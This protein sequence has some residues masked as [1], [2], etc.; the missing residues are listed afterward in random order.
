MDTNS[1]QNNL[2]K[3][4]SLKIFETFKKLMTFPR[5]LNLICSQTAPENY[6][7]RFALL[8]RQDNDLVNY[9]ESFTDLKSIENAFENSNSCSIKLN[10]P[11]NFLTIDKSTFD[12]AK[13]KYENTNPDF[14]IIFYN[15]YDNEGMTQGTTLIKFSVAES[16]R[17]LINLTNYNLQSPS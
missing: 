12:Y 5:F 9:N 14:I 17:T 3:I 15:I 13:N 2:N 6:N 7:K 11:D 10:Q 1:S 8:I 4:C 16:C